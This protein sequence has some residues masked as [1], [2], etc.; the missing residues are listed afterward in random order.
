MR[1]FI[2][3]IAGLA[4]APAWSALPPPNDEQKSRAAAAAVKAAWED[5]VALYKLCL[6]M[7]RTAAAYRRDARAAGHEVAPPTPTPSCADPGPAP[8][9]ATATASRPL[10]A[11][12]AHSPPETAAGPPSTNKPAAETSGGRARTATHT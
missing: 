4:L 10:E 2:A 8:A 3:L 12:G 11:S 9:P 5:K 6:A 7:D 1:T